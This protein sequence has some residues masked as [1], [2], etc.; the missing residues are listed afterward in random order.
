MAINPVRASQV[1]SRLAETNDPGKTQGK[2]DASFG[3][4]LGELL[5]DVNGLQQEAS[6]SA[7][8]LVAGKVDN[9]HEVMMAMGKAEVSFKFMA[10]VR[11]K[12][13]DA[14]REVMRMQV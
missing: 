13:I 11:N 7:R 2:G 3:K 9:L 10:Q 14:Y 6:D 4:A 8:N 1:A 5:K 12:L